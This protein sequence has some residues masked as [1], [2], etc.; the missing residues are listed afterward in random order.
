MQKFLRIVVGLVLLSECILTQA[1]GSH[2]SRGRTYNSKSSSGR[3]KRG[4]S[5]SEMQDME[6]MNDGRSGSGSGKRRSGEKRVKGGSGKKSGK[7]KSLGITQTPTIS[8]SPT[9]SLLPTIDSEEPTP[10][11]TPGPTEPPK[12]SQPPVENMMMTNMPSSMPSSTPTLVLSTGLPTS[13]TRPPLTNVPTN[14]P[15]DSTNL[16][17]GLQVGVPKEL[18]GT[19]AMCQGDCDNDDQC[20]GNLRC[21]RRSEF[22]PV[23]GCSGEELM[24]NINYCFDATGYLWYLSNDGGDADILSLGMCDGDC[25]TDDDCDGNLRCFFRDDFE[26]VPGCDSPFP[27]QIGEYGLDYCFDTTGYLSWVGDDLNATSYETYSDKI[28]Y[29]LGVCDGDCDDDDDCA[30]GLKCYNRYSDETVPGCINPYPVDVVGTDGYSYH[31]GI[32]F[33]YEP[34]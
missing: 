14:D 15:M 22:E 17:T 9:I 19:I 33:C 16:P 32:D 13:D 8:L 5:H 20:E 27:D 21:F 34:E 29:P 23:P 26:S 1:K 3:G 18:P 25:D 31:S 11:P 4:H 28:T 2:R 12:P 6:G 10:T 30:E 24:E 7:K